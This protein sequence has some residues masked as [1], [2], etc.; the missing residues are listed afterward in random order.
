MSPHVL[1]LSFLDVIQ[2]SYWQN[3]ITFILNLVIKQEAFPIN[4]CPCSTN[5]RRLF[6][7]NKGHP[8]QKVA[9]CNPNLIPVCL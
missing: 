6:S 2:I 3:Y 7:E 1:Y 8:V 9:P 4:V 5:L